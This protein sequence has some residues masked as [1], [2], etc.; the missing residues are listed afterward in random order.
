M[1]NTNQTWAHYLTSNPWQIAYLKDV[2]ISPVKTEVS[3][4]GKRTAYFICNDELRITVQKFR[5]NQNDK[6]A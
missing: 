4:T 5:T 2:G 6:E 3:V 1:E